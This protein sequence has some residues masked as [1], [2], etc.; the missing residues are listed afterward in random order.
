MSKVPKVYSADPE[1]RGH[2]R[3]L[4]TVLAQKWTY[5]GG[6]DPKPNQSA[7]VNKSPVTREAFVNMFS[8]CFTSFEEFSADQAFTEVS[9]TVD[10]TFLNP[11]ILAVAKFLIL[12]HELRVGVKLTGEQLMS[13]V[14]NG[15]IW[16][17]LLKTLDKKPQPKLENQIQDIHRYIVMLLNYDAQI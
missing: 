14:D 17:A 6:K 5:M 4:S 11:K 15:K 3:S 8:G 1:A 7:A 13:W 10:V 12:K 9:S 16:P 2:A